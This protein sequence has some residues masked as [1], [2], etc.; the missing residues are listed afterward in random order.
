M[1]T[2]KDRPNPPWQQLPQGRERKPARTPLS[3][4]RIV[5]AALEVLVAEGYD[6]VSMRR[7][8]QELGT[9]AASLYAHVANKQELDQLMVDRVGQSFEVPDP[10]PERW[11]EHVAQ[12]MRDMLGAMRSY[13]GVARA[14]IGQIPLGEHALYSTDRILAILRAAGLPDQ[15]CAYAVDFIS[16]YVCAVA[17]E[18]AVQGAAS[19]TPEDVE[20][21]VSELR[22]WFA[23]LPADRYP[24]IVALAAPLTAGGG[25]ERFEFGVKVIVGGLAAFLD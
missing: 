4:E 1:A 10:D 11:Q 24:N 3:R 18:E 25:D 14:A 8:A 21:F 9:G 15:V 12:L 17:F 7:V 23:A 6:A 16:L 13:P 2:D 20:K 22:D 19:W 5:D